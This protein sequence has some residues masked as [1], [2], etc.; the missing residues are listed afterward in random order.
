MATLAKGTQ[1]KISD[2]AMSPTFTAITGI[3]SLTWSGVSYDTEDITNHDSTDR[4]KDFVTTLY[5]NGEFSLKITW[6]ATNTQHAALRT[7]SESGASNDFQIAYTGSSAEA[8][9]FAGFVKSF[10]YVADVKNVL[11]AEVQIMVNGHMDDVS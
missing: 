3:T 10:K 11:S 1:F 7:L 9:Q 5:T 8:R 4:A 6:D 2:M